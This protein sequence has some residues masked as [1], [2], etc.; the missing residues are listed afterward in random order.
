MRSENGKF[1]NPLNLWAQASINGP[2]D[3]K[4]FNFLEPLKERKKQPPT[5]DIRIVRSYPL[6]GLNPEPRRSSGTPWV[7]EMHL[8]RGG[9]VRYFTSAPEP[10]RRIRKFFLECGVDPLVCLD[11][12]TE[13]G[14]LLPSTFPALA[15]SAEPYGTRQKVM[16]PL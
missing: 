9:G 8:I 4:R 11:S 10:K 14:P 15:L 2:N 3:F 12:R 1:D 6:V 5:N 16:T 13:S 7:P